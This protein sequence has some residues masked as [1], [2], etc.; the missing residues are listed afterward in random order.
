MEPMSAAELRSLGDVIIPQAEHE[1]NRGV[2]YRRRGE[3]QAARDAFGRAANMGA[4]YISAKAALNLGLLL[5][6]QWH[7]LE[8]ARREYEQ[9]AALGRNT[10]VAPNAELLLGNVHALRGD[11]NAAFRAFKR[12]YESGLPPVVPK[13]IFAIGLLYENVGDLSGARLAFEAAMETQDP[14]IAP[15]AAARLDRLAGRG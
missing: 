8:G 4:F 5:E 6:E 3:W 13:A 7:D 2:E 14:R 1:Y 15:Q 11:G 10:D 12:A 9:A